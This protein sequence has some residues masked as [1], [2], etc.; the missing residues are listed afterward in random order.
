MIKVQIFKKENIIYAFDI[1]G[2]AS[3]DEYGKDIICS[4]VS[5]LVTNT[6]N[7]IDY[8]TDDDIKLEANNE[9]TGHIKFRVDI[10]KKPYSRDTD[11]LLRSLELGLKNVVEQ[12]GKKYIE[13]EEVQKNVT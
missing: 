13:I 10:S 3:Y 9:K 11:I 2:H 4:A 6:I 7:S 5:M 12:Y 1:L 8:F